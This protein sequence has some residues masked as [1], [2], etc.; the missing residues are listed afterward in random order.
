MVHFWFPKRYRKEAQDGVKTFFERPGPTTRKSQPIIEDETVR[1]KTKEKIGKVLKRRYLLPSDSLVK[2][3]IKYFAVPK[4]EDDICMVYNA[5]A[6]KL[7]EAVWVPTFW[8][9]TID[10]LVRA[11]GLTSW[12]TDRDVG[13]MFLNYQLQEDVKP[14]TG[15]DL[16]SLYDGPEDPGPRMAV[17]DRNLMGFAASPYNS[18]KM[19]LVAE[20]ICKGD[21]FE[22]GIGC[23]G[24]ELNPFQ[25]EVISLNLP[26]TKDYDPRFSWIVKRRKDGQI[27]CDLFTFVDNER[28]VGP[29]EE[30]TWQAS[31]VL[32]SKQSYLGIQDAARKAR[33][34]S[35]TTG[36][37]AS[38]IVH[39]VDQLGVCVL[40]SKE[41]W[42]KMQGILEKWRAALLDPI[43]TLSHKE[44]LSNRGFLVYVTRTYPAMV[45]YLKGFHLTIEMWCGGRNF[46]VWKLKTSDASS[47]EGDDV[48]APDGAEDEDEAAANHRILIKLGAG[49]AYAP[50]DGLTTLV[51]RFRDN[52]NPLLQLT[53]FDLPPLH[54]MRPAHVVHVYY[55]FGDASGKQ[56]GANLSERYS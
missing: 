27:A 31:H 20:E 18:I 24:K 17:W 1:V 25:L 50:E 56:F 55:G 16:T 47:L 15:V 45:P 33:P 26:G 6:N 54:V 13:D 36:A 22:T 21:C 35:Q 46:E 4:G 8:L 11:V 29:T 52:I 7:N 41:K 43:P 30:L 14:F 32:A 51:P 28:V 48:P 3:Y 10:L 9:P 2:S 53:N 34:C 12:V 23:D 42:A 38:A 49:H 44:L 37:W 39:I 19:A 5:T 40:T